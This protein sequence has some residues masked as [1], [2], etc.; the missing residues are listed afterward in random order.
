MD[1]YFAVKGSSVGRRGGK[2]PPEKEKGFEFSVHPLAVLPFLCFLFFDGGPLFFCACLAAG[3]HELGHLAA[4]WM[5]GGRVVRFAIHPFGAEIVTGGKMLSY[6][7]ELF[8]SAAGVVTNALCAL[9]LFL[10]GLP[11]WLEVFSA[12]SLG[13]ALFNLLPLKRLDGGEMAESLCAMLFGPGGCG[14]LCRILSVFGVAL[15][16]CFLMLGIF[17]A[18]FNPLFLLMFVYLLWGVF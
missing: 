4:I 5:A 17:F 16:F 1:G 3:L 7:R 2:A 18:R 15:L 8:V 10:S 12:C 9:P 11:Y 6:G 14:V 13:L